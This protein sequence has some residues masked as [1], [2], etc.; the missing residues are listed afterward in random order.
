VLHGFQQMPQDQQVANWGRLKADLTSAGFNPD[1]MPPGYD[2][3]YID[4]NLKKS[5]SIADQIKLAEGTKPINVAPGGTLVDPKTKQPIFT[6]P[7]K[8]DNALVE[9]ADPSSPTGTRMVP[10][11]QAVN[12]PGKPPSTMSLTSDGKGGFEFTQ[13]RTGPAGLAKPTVNMIEEQIANN[14]LRLDRLNTIGQGMRPEFMQFGT[15]VANWGAAFAE[16]AGANLDPKTKAGL[17]AYTNFRS[18]AY[19]DLSRTLK[20]MSGAAVTP[21]EAERLLKSIGDPSN[22]SPTEF[23]A[24][25]DATVKAVRLAQARLHWMRKNGLGGEKMGSVGL[26]DMDGIIRNRWKALEAEAKGNGASDDDAY[27]Q[28]RAVVAQEFGIKL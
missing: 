11:A 17:A 18:D 13:G 3:G 6:A 10:R 21:Q 19:N 16:K 20:E 12:Q 26:D 28:S 27:N 5:L 14:S 25:Y 23:K 8:A 9:I 24:K 4:F 7:E 22:D 1:D 15:K 2:P